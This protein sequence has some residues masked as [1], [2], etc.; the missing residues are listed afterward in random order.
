M[1]IL[2]YVFV[3]LVYLGGAGILLILFLATGFHVYRK[4]LIPFLFG[5]SFDEFEILVT[6]LAQPLTWILAVIAGVGFFGKA[7]VAKRQRRVFEIDADTTR[8]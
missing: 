6:V 1:K 5:F 4:G 7:Y 3:S 2:G 8:P